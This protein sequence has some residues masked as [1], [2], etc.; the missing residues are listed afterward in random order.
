M[1]VGV[2]EIKSRSLALLAAMTSLLCILPFPFQNFSRAL[3]A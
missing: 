1:M 2:S 3:L